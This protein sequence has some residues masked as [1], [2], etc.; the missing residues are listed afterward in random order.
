MPIQS[1]WSIFFQTFEINLYDRITRSKQ[2]WLFLFHNINYL[3]SPR[4]NFS[5][6]SCRNP[7][8]LLASTK[9]RQLI[10]FLSQSLSINIINKMRTPLLRLSKLTSIIAEEDLNTAGYPSFTTWLKHFP[11]S[12]WLILHKHF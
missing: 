2:R 11:N 7:F 3:K 10:K 6:H 4:M 5:P 1:K 8:S 9:C 12:V